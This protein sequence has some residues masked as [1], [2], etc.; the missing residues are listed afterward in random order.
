MCADFAARLHIGEDIRTAKRVNRLFWIAN[1]QKCGIR[2]MLPDPT[3][4]TVLLRIGILEF[5]DHGNRKTG[6]NSRRQRIAAF[7][8][9]RCI[10]TAE[11]IVKTQLA[12]AAFLLGNRRADL[13]QRPG[14]HQ[15]AQG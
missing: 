15:I 7:T 14:D 4:N 11:H 12:A 1:Q 6:A 2:L 10:Q 8:A 13:R 3:K 9:Q 5:I